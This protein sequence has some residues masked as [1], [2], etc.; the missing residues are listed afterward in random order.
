M[1]EL[2]YKDLSYRLVGCCIRVQNTLGSGHKESVYQKSLAI[3]LAKDNI[4]FEEQ[5]TL[6]MLY[7]NKKVGI[8]RPDF[9]VED[10]IVIEIK[11]VEFVPKDYERQL[12]YYLK[13]TN[14]KLGYL[15]NFGTPSLYAKR[16]IWSG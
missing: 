12:I 9:I 15:I 8:Y 3:E 5:K 14:Y 1:S 10:K 11:A 6:N 4:R 13:G 16:I 2:L 7:D